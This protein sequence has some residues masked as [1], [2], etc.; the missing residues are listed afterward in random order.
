MA[1]QNNLG[2]RILP[3]KIKAAF[4]RGKKARDQKHYLPGPHY[5][6]ESSNMKR[7]DQLTISQLS[8]KVLS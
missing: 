5:I 2:H 6:A 1:H 8:V 3:K 7:E 4:T